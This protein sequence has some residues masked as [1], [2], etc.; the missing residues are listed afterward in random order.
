[1]ASY[2]EPD[3]LHASKKGGEMLIKVIGTVLKQKGKQTPGRNA[4]VDD[5]GLKDVAYSVD[6]DRTSMTM[7]A[8][9][10]TMQVDVLIDTVV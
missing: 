5:C 1:M 4:T 6:F 7:G 10:G 3:G 9:F 8:R 2:Y